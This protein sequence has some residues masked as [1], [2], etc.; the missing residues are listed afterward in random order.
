MKMIFA[1]ALLRAIKPNSRHISAAGK[2][3]PGLL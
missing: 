3:S 1:V 2:Q